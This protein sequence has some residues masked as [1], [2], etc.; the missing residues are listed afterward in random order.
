M[1]RLSKIYESILLFEGRVEK[2]RERYPMINDIVF[3]HYVNADP[4]GN[5]KYLDWM[6]GTT[7]SDSK[8]FQN[9]KGTNPVLR[10]DKRPVQYHVDMV[11]AINF[12]HNNQQRFKEKDINQYKSLVELE[13][14]VESVKEKIKKKEEEKRI[15]KERDIIYNDENW[16]VVVPKS[17]LASCKYGSGT[18]WCVTMS[19]QP[20]YYKQYTRNATLFF[21]IDKTKDESDPLYKV[22]FR[23]IGPKGNKVELWDATDYEFSNSEKGDEYLES[24]PGKLRETISIY[25]ATNYEGGDPDDSPQAQAI[26][27]VTGV[28]HV[29]DTDE[30]HYGMPI[31]ETEEGDFYVVGDEDDMAEAVRARYEDETDD[32]LLSI[33]DPNG[34]YLE[35]YNPEDFARE[36]ANHWTHE[37]SDEEKLEYA[38]M[39]DEYWALQ[40][41]LEELQ[42]NEEEFSE[43]EEERIL[44]QMERIVDEAEEQVWERKYEEVMDCLDG[45]AYQCLVDIYGWFSGARD[46]LDS[47]LVHLDRGGLI[48]SLV[49]YGDWEM[50]AYNGYDYGEDDEG[51]SWI[52]FEIDY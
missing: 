33:Y 6:L 29:V 16:L 40:N 45:G 7:L 36:E 39:E 28:E 30:Y 9:D 49:G 2:A 47:G 34:Y 8:H 11:N 41:E 12:F 4:S 48:D 18:K 38:S 25:H 31:F 10:P 5:Q 26:K 44:S 35:M 43:A 15:K 22:A 51:R 13:S 24:L 42:D 23:M 27:D 52:V 32:E 19:D 37:L 50:I 3:N 20:N 46:L 14:Q 17:H 1:E 21:I